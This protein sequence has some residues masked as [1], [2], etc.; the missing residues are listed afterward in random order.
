MRQFLVFIYLMVLVGGCG[1]A[2]GPSNIRAFKKI[3]LKENVSITIP[4]IESKFND[5]LTFKQIEIWIGNDK[6]FTDTSHTEYLFDELNNWPK[7]RRLRSGDYEVLMKVLGAPDLN[8]LSA[9][10]IKDLK[11][12]GKKVF[13]YFEQTPRDY[14]N[15]G[16][17]EYSGTLN[18]AEAYQSNDS[19]YYNPTLY[20]KDTDDG[21]QLD[22]VLTIKMIRKIWGDFHGLVRTELVLPCP[23]N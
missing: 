17:E 2:H 20:F 18:I 23:K 19:C 13:P 4:I 10:Y 3:M 12:K 7:A 1:K 5:S 22:S 11:I 15:D 14:D 8:K 6:V 16:V 21:L 9:F